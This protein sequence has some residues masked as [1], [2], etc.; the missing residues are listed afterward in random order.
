MRHPRRAH[1][2]YSWRRSSGVDREWQARDGCHTPHDA[3][4]KIRVRVEASG[5]YRRARDFFGFPAFLAAAGAGA[6]G[7]TTAMSVM[8]FHPPPACFAQHVT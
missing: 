6:A 7:S 2:G 1:A 3:C 8:A 5:A 4:V